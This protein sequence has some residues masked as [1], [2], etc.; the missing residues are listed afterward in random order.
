MTKQLAQGDGKQTALPG[1]INH[2]VVDRYTAAHLAVGVLM[3]AA[4]VPWWGATGAAVG[5][6][7]AER[8]LK[9]KFPKIFPHATQDT[10]ANM[11]GD[12]V[13]MVGGWVLWQVLARR[14]RQ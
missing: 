10:P 11:I 2:A 12:A 9:R 3:G 1:H 5:W 7:I 4:R 6:E 14:K 8:P 13:A